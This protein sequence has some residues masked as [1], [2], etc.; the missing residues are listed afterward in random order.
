MKTRD[1]RTEV[2]LDWW[3]DHHDPDKSIY[4]FDEEGESM[5]LNP[6]VEVSIDCSSKPLGI[7]PAYYEIYREPSYRYIKRMTGSDLIWVQNR[8]IPKGVL[9]P[10]QKDSTEIEIKKAYVMVPGDPS[11]GIFSST[12]T[13]DFG[14]YTTF[15]DEVADVKKTL[16]D[17]FSDLMGE[18]IGVMFDYEVEEERKAEMKYMALEK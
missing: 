2:P 18:K 15:T 14:S 16:V 4:L 9:L 17:A 12:I 3:F 5:G 1:N 8:D 10:G 7:H 11:V 6:W 13:I